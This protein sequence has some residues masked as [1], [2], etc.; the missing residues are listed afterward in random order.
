MASMKTPI[1]KAQDLTVIIDDTDANNVYIGKAT[2][3]STQ[4]A[5]VWSIRKII[6]NGGIITIAWAQGTNAANNVWNSRTGYAYS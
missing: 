2:I 6:T 3:G 1:A 4:S 5:S